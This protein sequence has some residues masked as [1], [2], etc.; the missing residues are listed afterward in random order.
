MKILVRHAGLKKVEA[1]FDGTKVMTDQTPK[2][3]GEGSAPTPFDL[4]LTSLATCSGYYV[5][6]F[7][8]ERK[9]PIDGVTLCMTTERSEAKKMLDRVRIEIRLPADFPE[10][11]EKAVVRAANLCSVKK[12]LM[13]PLAIETFATRAGS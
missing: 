9:I 10:K 3:G 6:D 8:Q 11:Y 1:S 7:C 12:H 5:Y 13:E 4:F 2:D